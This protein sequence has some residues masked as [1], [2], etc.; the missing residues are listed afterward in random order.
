[1]IEL[2]DGGIETHL[3]FHAGF[4]LPCFASFPLLD[5]TRGRAAIRDYFAPFVAIADERGLPFALDTATWRANPDWGARLG[6][7]DKALAAANRD[8]VAFARELAGGRP[9]TTINGVIGRA[10]TAT[11]PASG[12]PR[13]PRRS[14]TRGRSACCATPAWSGSR[15]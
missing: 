12:C 11:S 1:M 5:H 6:Y 2:T 7:G 10:A 14:T 4:E 3:L 8:A 9:D 15:R 13:T